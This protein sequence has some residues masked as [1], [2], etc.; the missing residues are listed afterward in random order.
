MPRSGRAVSPAFNRLWMASAITNL[1]DGA[2]LAAG[3]LLVATLTTDPAAVAVAGIAQ[4]LPAPLFGLVG[5]ALADRLS[6]RTLVVV[7]NASRAALLAC[8]AVTIATG[9]VSLWLPYLV[10]AGC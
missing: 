6:R 8:L 9:T 5:G 7:A 3:P 10:A 2:L 4:R 1:G